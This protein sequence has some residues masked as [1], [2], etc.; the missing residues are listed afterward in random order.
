MC[1]SLGG[2]S[3][4]IVAAG[5]LG[6]PAVEQQARV[7][8][9]FSDSSERGGGEFRNPNPP[10]PRGNF[11]EAPVLHGGKNAVGSVRAAQ[12]ERNYHA[13]KMAH[14]DFR[15]RRRPQRVRPAHYRCFLGES[16]EVSCRE[17]KLERNHFRN[18]Q[19]C[20]CRRL[21][22]ARKRRQN[23]QNGNTIRPSFSILGTKLRIFGLI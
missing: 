19:F 3:Q 5:G 8:E 14:S 4:R 20:Q 17:Q 13:R 23:S 6:K 2:V 9:D 15:V 1:L 10:R 21:R 7:G 11:G 22:L 16:A 18:F 12:Q